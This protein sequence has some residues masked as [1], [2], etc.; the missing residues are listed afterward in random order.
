MDGLLLLCH[1]FN[2]VAVCVLSLHHALNS[3]SLTT[4]LQNTPM[5]LCENVFC[6][7]LFTLDSL[8]VY[9]RINLDVTPIG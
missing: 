4:D 1:I 7:L 2:F 9:Y 6:C 8:C 3:G 5:F